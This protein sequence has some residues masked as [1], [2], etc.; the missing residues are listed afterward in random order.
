MRSLQVTD[1]KEGTMELRLLMSA[2]SSGQTFDLRC[3][4]REKLIDFLQR[5][6][7][8]ALPHSRQIAFKSEAESAPPSPARSR[9]E[10]PPQA[11]A[12]PRPAAFLIIDCSALLRRRSQC[13]YLALIAVG[14]R[15]AVARIR[16]SSAADETAERQFTALGKPRGAFPAARL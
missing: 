16:L 14:H 7:P 2:R 9:A 8:E 11:V 6:H 15:A 13:V 3:E 1:F 12:L 4:V 10:K 5:E